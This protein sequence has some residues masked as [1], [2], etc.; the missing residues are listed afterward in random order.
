[1]ENKLQFWLPLRADFIMMKSFD[2][3]DYGNQVFDREQLEKALAM[4]YSRVE[5]RQVGK[6]S[7]ISVVDEESSSESEEVKETTIMDPVKFMERN[8]GNISCIP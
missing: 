7:R 8:L 5:I 2:K 4:Q 6:K 3:L 1:M